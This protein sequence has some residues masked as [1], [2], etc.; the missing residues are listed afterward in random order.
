LDAILT[1]RTANDIQIRQ[2]DAAQGWL[3]NTTTH[4]IAPMTQYEENPLEAAWLPNE[5][6]AR[7]WQEYVN[8]GIENRVKY[9]LCK[10]EKIFSL[11]G[12]PHSIKN[13]STGKISPTQKPAAPTDLRAIKIRGTEVV[14]TWNFFPDLENG[15]PSFRIYRDDSPIATLLGQVHNFSDAP[16][17]PNVVL[18]FRDKGATANAIYTVSAFNVLG[19]SVSQPTRLIK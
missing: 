17:P 15:L 19:E 18:E 14:L 8:T 4:A 5:A 10:S 11:L 9:V 7:K 3:G 13:C 12:I 6:T 1:A 16:D 2:I